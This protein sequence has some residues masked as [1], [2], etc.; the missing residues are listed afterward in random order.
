MQERI[1]SFLAPVSFAQERILIDERIR[2]SRVDHAIYGITMAYRLSST[3]RSVSIS[4]LC[5]AIKTVSIRHKVL[6]TALN[7]DATGVP[8]QVHVPVDDKFFHVEIDATDD[9]DDFQKI[10]ERIQCSNEFD[11]TRGYVFHSHIIRQHSSHKSFDDD[12]LTTD[13][14]I[15]FNIHHSVFDGASMMIFLRDLNLAYDL[16]GSLPNNDNLLQYTDYSVYERLTDMTLSKQFWQSQ[17]HGYDIENRLTLSSD[18][19]R[20]AGSERSSLA[21]SIQSSVSDDLSRSILN[22]ASSKQI[23]LFQL[24]LS[25]FYAFLFKLSNADNDLCVACINANRYRTE[26]RDLIGMFVATLPYRIRF[27][28]EI[29]FEQLVEHVREQSLS[30]L[31]HSYYPLQYILENSGHARSNVAFLEV[32]YDQVT[33]SAENNQ[34][35]LDEALLKPFSSNGMNNL[36]KFDFMFTLLYSPNTIDSSISCSIVC[37]RDRFDQSTVHTLANRYSSLLHQLFHTDSMRNREK[38]LYNLSVVLPHELSLFKA[39]NNSIRDHRTLPTNTIGQLFSEVAHRYSQ[40][41]AI[42]LD[43]QSLTYD[44][45]LYYVQKL[46]TYLLYTY[47]IKVG[48]IICQ[49]VERSLSMVITST[50]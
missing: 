15:I 21:S 7:F 22:Y 11:L 9:D 35:K 18:R 38:S 34:L 45:L 16:D 3:D 43:D 48:N 40:K 42:E 1:C 24:G 39:L 13:D 50:Y 6:H 26:L 19:Y 49:C 23:T 47:Q 27:D 37:S 28:S 20:V 17:L 14:A 36:A 29:S 33:F 10:Y 2:F 5:R 44:E 4:R 46:A 12:L 41:I 30:I 25:L 31:Q 32:V 8:V